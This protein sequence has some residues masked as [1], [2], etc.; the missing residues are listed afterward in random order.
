M[1]IK[2]VVYIP[3]RGR[4]HNIV[5]VIPRWLEQKYEVRVVV[6]AKDFDEYHAAIKPT[7]AGRVK[8]LVLPESDRG[9]GYARQWILEH[10]AF[11]WNGRHKINSEK[12]LSSFIMADDDVMPKTPGKGWTNNM[13][14]LQ[15]A[16]ES[17]KYIG[18]AAVHGYQDFTT[19]GFLKKELANPRVTDS[20]A[21]VIGRPCLAPTGLFGQCFAINT[22]RALVEVGG[23]DPELTVAYED[24]D[25]MMRCVSRGVPWLFHS[26]VWMDRLGGRFETGG[27]SDYCDVSRDTA[28]QVNRDIHYLIS[29]GDEYSQKLLD[30]RLILK[31]KW[32]F[33]TSDPHGRQ[34]RISWKKLY[35]GQ[36]PGWKAMSALHGG[37]LPARDGNQ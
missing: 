10:A 25:F 23:F 3:S 36:I 29:Q 27:I 32:D 2:R 9:I 28:K 20:G 19:G 13:V 14:R 16:V 18:C 15:Q 34:F 31:R 7:K 22:Y 8:L 4:V 21:T 12:A 26:G 33:Y 17:G 30:C 5:K 37:D 24:N 1:T 6:E 11:K 35:D